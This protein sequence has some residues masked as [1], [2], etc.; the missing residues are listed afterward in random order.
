MTD[1]GNP[2]NPLYKMALE[3]V[4]ADYEHELMLTRCE[5]LALERSRN[6]W[7]QSAMFC[8]GQVVALLTYILM[9]LCK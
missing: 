8:C 4:E 2:L 3:Q 5:V 7:R 9:E 1:D 6:R